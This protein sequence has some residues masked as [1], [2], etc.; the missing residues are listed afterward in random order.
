MGYHLLHDDEHDVAVIYCSNTGRAL[1]HEVFQGTD[2]YAQGESFMGWLLAGAYDDVIADDLAP[3]SPGRMPNLSDPRAYT[4]QGLEKVHGQW[5]E[6]CIDKT[7][8]ELNGYGRQLAEWFN[9]DRDEP[10][11]ARL[12]VA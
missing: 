2:A 11:P 7:V 10:A 5:R 12:Q 3:P 9:S 6:Q 4:P 8:G 1:S